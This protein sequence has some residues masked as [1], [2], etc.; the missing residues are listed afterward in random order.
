ME[1]FL[2]ALVLSG[3]AIVQAPSAGA[4][5]QAAAGT[6]PVIRS[7]APSADMPGVP[8]AP[9]GRSTIMGGAIRDVDSLRDQ[10]SLQVVG[11]R[12]VKILFDE[13]TRVFRDGKPIP[14]LA[15]AAADHASVQTVLDRTNI[16]A[17][18]VH[19]LSQS[20][21]GECQGRVVRYDQGSGQLIVDSDLTHESIRLEVPAGTPVTRVGQGSFTSSH[22]G[23]SDL[24]EGALVSVKFASDSQGHPIAHGVEV[25]AVPG[26]SFVFDGTVSFLDLHA[27]RLVIADPLDGR[28]YVIALDPARTP[29]STNLHEGQQ[30]RVNAR[31]DGNRYMADEI[32]PK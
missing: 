3:A 19:I 28:T 25:L 11:Q 32:T 14:L 23:A 21:E 20:P 31:Y 5:T 13:R 30:I 26:S 1:R 15:L 12:P 2:A 17:L 10:F 24:M 18:S 16:D 22:A 4:Q 29:A 6:N 8:P 7:G 9:K 27:G